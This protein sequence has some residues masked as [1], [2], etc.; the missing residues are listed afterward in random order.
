VIAHLVLFRPRADLTRDAR[1]G[2]ADALSSA[3]REIPSIRHASLGERILHGRPY[4]RS[5]QTHYSHAALLEF[6]DL[7]GLR[8]YLDHPAHAPLALRFF[9]AF[10]EALMYDYEMLEGE[11]G[12]EAMRRDAVGG[13]QPDRG[14]D[15]PEK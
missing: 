5:L 4:E 14:P 10:E 1:A 2:L 8:A 12:V 7:A 6:D 9:E 11:A 3:L 13:L 15:A